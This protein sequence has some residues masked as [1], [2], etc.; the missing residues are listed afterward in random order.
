[1]HNEADLIN[2]M[3]IK[4]KEGN[5]RMIQLFAIVSKNGSSTSIQS[6]AESRDCGIF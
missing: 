5:A 1:M 2:A 6:T 3:F 4:Q